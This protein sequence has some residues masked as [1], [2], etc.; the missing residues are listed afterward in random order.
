MLTKYKPPQGKASVSHKKC[1]TQY[2]PTPRPV[3]NLEVTLLSLCYKEKEDE[4]D[5]ED[6]EEYED[7]DEK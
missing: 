6:E 4:E 3:Q 5:Y 7:E 1:D 2:F